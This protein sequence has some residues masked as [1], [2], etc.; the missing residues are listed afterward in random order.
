[1]GFGNAY[2]LAED[3]LSANCH[4]GG[5]ILSGMPATTAS[6]LKPPAELPFAEMEEVSTFSDVAPLLQMAGTLELQPEAS[7]ALCRLVSGGY[8]SAWPLLQEPELTGEV[9]AQLLSSD[10]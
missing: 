9:F 4:S 10:S 6:S 2:R 7:A 3:F 8:R 5:A 1:M